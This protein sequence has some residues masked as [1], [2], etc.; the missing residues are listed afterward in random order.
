MRGYIYLHL[1]LIFMVD[2]GKY[3]TDGSYGVLEFEDV[4]V[5]D[6]F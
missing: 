2:I 3:T 4:F 1:M 5:Q 6:C